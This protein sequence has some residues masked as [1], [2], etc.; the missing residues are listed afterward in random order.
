[1]NKYSFLLLAVVIVLLPA[2]NKKKINDLER[3]LALKNQQAEQ[4][5]RQLQTIQATNASL[6]DRLADLS[7]INK[8]GAESIQ[9]SLEN[10]NKQY[11][12]IENLTNKIQQKDSLNLVLVMN[13]RRSLADISDDD[14]QIE[15]RGGMVHVSISDK[16]LFRSGSFALGNQAKNILGKLAAVINEHDDLQ[17]M[18]EGHTDNV[19]MHN[20]CLQDNW[21]LSAMR[22][23]SVVR[24]LQ[25]NYYVA[26]DRLSASGRSEYLPK[27]DNSTAEGRAE[28]RRTEIVI[29]PRLDQ[30]FKLLESPQL[31][32]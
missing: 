24:S 22:A 21:D 14:L 25:L 18:V 29:M 6:L 27:A 28:N 30:Y 3:E 1:M 8:A 12:F 4:L 10:I 26:P 23:T 15:V 11:S 17:I 31:A 9:Q 16:M 19:P 13:L 2:C 20:E 32:D 5:D 7:V